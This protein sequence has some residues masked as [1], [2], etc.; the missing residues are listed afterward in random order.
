MWKYFFFVTEQSQYPIEPK[1]CFAHENAY[2]AV[3]QVPLKIS[4][5]KCKNIQYRLLLQ[6]LPP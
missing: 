3:F 6:T 4:R 2:Q 5:G 1:Q